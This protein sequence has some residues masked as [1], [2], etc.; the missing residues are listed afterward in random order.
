MCKGYQQLGRPLERNQCCITKTVGFIFIYVYM[1]KHIEY[2]TR[3][4]LFYR[5]TDL[6]LIK[7][8]KKIKKMYFKI[9]IYGGKCRCERVNIFLPRC[10]QYTYIYI[11][12]NE[13]VSKRRRPP[14]G[15]KSI[16][17]VKVTRYSI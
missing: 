13:N 16:S 5:E 4:Y 1:H 17:D 7:N 12:I 8:I 6:Y 15:T 14:D 10:V 3:I 2:N 9:Y 11:F